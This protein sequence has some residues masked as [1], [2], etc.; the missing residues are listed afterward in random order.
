M[1]RELKRCHLCNNLY[2]YLC[3]KDPPTCRKC[4]TPPKK[5]CQRCNQLSKMATKALCYNCYKFNRKVICNKCGKY[6]TIGLK[7]NGEYICSMCY[8]KYYQPREICSRCLILKKVAARIDGKPVCYYCREFNSSCD[9]CG[10]TNRIAKIKNKQKICIKCYKTPKDICSMCKKLA[11]VAQR[12]NKVICISCY[13]SPKETC[14][15]CNSLSYVATRNKEQQPLCVK[16][17]KAECYKCNKLLRICTRIDGEIY[18]KNCYHKYKMKNNSTYALYYTVRHSISRRLRDYLKSRK[19][20]ICEYG[21]D[22]KAAAKH[23]GYKPNDGY[24]YHIDHI[25]PVYA[26]DFTDHLHIRACFAPENLQWL[27]VKDNLKKGFGYDKEEFNRYIESFIK[28]EKKD[29]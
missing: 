19:L 16:C 10:K 22:Y 27:K 21:I 6:N 25:L 8:A 9:L 13:K 11:H 24:K 4:Y 3:V 15:A 14:F 5:V 18:C 28:K 23:I 1:N 29:G 17:N 20:P 2:K 12:K 7:N 26:F